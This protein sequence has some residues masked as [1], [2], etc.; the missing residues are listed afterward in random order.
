MER[1]HKVRDTNGQLSVADLKAAGFNFRFDPNALELV[2]ALNADQ[3]PVGDLSLRRHNAPSVSANAV[4]PAI[5]SG[6]LNVFTGVRSSLGSDG[7]DERNQRPHGFRKRLPLLQRRRRERLRLRRPGQ[8]LHVAPSAPSAAYDH[9][10]GFKRRRSR[11][12]YDM[13]DNQM[14]VQLG[15]AET[16]GTG[17]QRAPDVLGVTVEKSPRKLRPG[18]SIRP[19]GRSSFRIERPSE[20]RSPRSMAPSCSASSS[21]P[22]TTICPICRSPPAP[23]TSS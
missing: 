18:E 22:A 4:R 12:V 19:T 6:Y 17:F 9:R 1:L 11:L 16:Y 5:F 2:F 7:R 13:P 3:R 20:R 21:A 23:T 14:R 15:D 10:D 8:H